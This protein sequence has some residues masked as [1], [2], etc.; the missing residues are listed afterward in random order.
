MTSEVGR[1]LRLSFWASLFLAIPTSRAR[2]THA[3]SGKS[4]SGGK[5]NSGAPS[6]SH[7]KKCS[8]WSVHSAAQPSSHANFPEDRMPRQVL[9]RAYVASTSMRSGESGGGQLGKSWGSLKQTV[10]KQKTS[11]DE[12]VGRTQ[13]HRFASQSPMYPSITCLCSTFGPILVAC[14]WGL[15]Q[16]ELCQES[17][18]PKKKPNAKETKQTGGRCLSLP[19]K[20]PD[21]Q[22]EPS[23]VIPSHMH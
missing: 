2:A 14:R 17:A 22:L 18:L 9:P 16:Y 11:G 15:V 4:S 10:V 5:K 3:G 7:D 19:D 1:G 20:F 21:P 13:Q 6:I 23:I 8:A 12:S